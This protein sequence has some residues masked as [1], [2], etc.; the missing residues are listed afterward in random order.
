MTAGCGW[1]PREGGPVEEI[2]PG[3]AVWFPPGEKHSHGATATAAMTHVAIQEKLDGKGSTGWR[4]FPT[5][6]TA[7]DVEQQLEFAQ[8]CQTRRETHGAESPRPTIRTCRRL[9]S[10]T[11]SS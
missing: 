1:A 11:N 7:S 4:R 6:S 8:Q 9:G 2:R 5:R 3:D 10:T